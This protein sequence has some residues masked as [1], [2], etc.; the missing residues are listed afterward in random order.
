MVCMVDGTPTM[1]APQLRWSFIGDIKNRQTGGTVILVLI[2]AIMAF[3]KI[4][5]PK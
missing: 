1:V 3:R 2:V 4:T 5:I